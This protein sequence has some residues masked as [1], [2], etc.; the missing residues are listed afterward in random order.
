MMGHRWFPPP[1]RSPPSKAQ[2]EETA[3]KNYKE[4]SYTEKLRTLSEKNW[5]R[6]GAL[7]AAR[8]NQAVQHYDT[9]VG[10]VPRTLAPTSPMYNK[11]IFTRDLLSGTL[12]LRR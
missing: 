5:Q 6:M 4:R 12:Q 7:E 8:A 10:S 3:K 1:T 2:I 9:F 11:G